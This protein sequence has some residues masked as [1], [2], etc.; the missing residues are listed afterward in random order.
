MKYTSSTIALIFLAALI[1]SCVSVKRLELS[2]DPLNQITNKKAGNILVK[3][4]VHKGKIPFIFPDP[5]ERMMRIG[6]K[7]QESAN[8]RKESMEK[9]EK[10]IRKYFE[11]LFTS[12]FAEALKIAG[13]NVIKEPV[14]EEAKNAISQFKEMKAHYSIQDGRRGG[15][16]PYAIVFPELQSQSANMPS[17]KYDAIAIIEGEILNF[18]LDLS[19]EWM[20]GIHH[21][22]LE[23]YVKAIDPINQKILWEKYIGGEV[24]NLAHV[25]DTVFYERAIRQAVTKA[26]N[27]AVKEFASDEFYK[28]IKNKK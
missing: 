15:I 25:S 4:F 11:V 20:T 8:K 21:S 18:Y 2:H 13:Y 10:L 23:A 14:S 16:S 24:K 5:M 1:S 7:A 3:Q 27:E 19:N 17:N 26:L 6:E 12:Y 9:R 28:A 22:K